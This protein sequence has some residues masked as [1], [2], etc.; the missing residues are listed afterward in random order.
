MCYLRVNSPFQGW[1]CSRAFSVT[2][3]ETHRHCAKLERPNGVASSPAGWENTRVGV[4]IAGQ[5]EHGES[6][7]KWRQKV[8]LVDKGSWNYLHLARP[9]GGD[10][11]H[12]Q[13]P[14]Q[15]VCETAKIT[16]EIANQLLNSYKI[17]G[18]W[19]CTVLW[20]ILEPHTRL[21]PHCGPTNA[22]LFITFY[23][24]INWLSKIWYVRK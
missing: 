15:E 22:R 4:Q 18:C 16:C 11:G 10:N 2:L 17:G 1:Y 9:S 24:L 8:G 20:S 21:K 19:T 7:V 3:A 13:P 14:Q 23:R 6:K 5:L 12:G